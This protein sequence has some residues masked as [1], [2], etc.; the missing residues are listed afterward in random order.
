MECNKS[1]YRNKVT[2]LTKINSLVRTGRWNRKDKSAR[3]Y[4]CDFC[5]AWHIS[6]LKEYE[7]EIEKIDISVSYKDRWDT[8]LKNNI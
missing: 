6:S 8:I 7:P 5:K 3:S 4:Y 1:K 2:V